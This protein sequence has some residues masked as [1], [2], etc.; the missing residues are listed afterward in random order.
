MP[1]GPVNAALDHLRRAAL[2]A[3][4]G[5]ADAELLGRF[6]EQRDADA[7][8]ALVGRHGPMVWGVCRR[9]LGY[10]DA[11]DAVQATFLVLVRKAAAV[12]PREAVG[13][14]LYGVAHRTALLARRTAARRRAREVQVP[15]LPES[16]AA[17]GHEFDPQLLDA[18]LRRLPDIYRAVLVLC[19]LEGRT[20]AEA[21]RTLGVPE[22]TVAGR[23]ARARALL[24][25]RLAAH[26][27]APAAAA[28]AALA[29]TAAAGS[30]IDAATRV[31]SGQA[32]I[33]VSVAA[34]TTGVT[35]A[36]LFTTV[37]AT[38]VVVLALGLAAA[39]ASSLNGRPAARQ[40][41]A[42]P[43]AAKAADPPPAKQKKDE[44]VVAWG[45]RVGGLQAGLV[46][47]GGAKK[48]FRH[49]DVVTLGVR[50]RNVGKEAV[51]FGYVPQH[52]DENPPTVTDADGATTPQPNLMSLGV[53]HP[54]VTV[55]LEPGKAV[56]LKSHYFNDAGREYALRPAD[57]PR[58]GQGRARPLFVGTGIVT[59]EFERVFGDSSIG[60]AEIPP[61][62]RRLRTGVLE[63]EVEP[64]AA[65]KK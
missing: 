24:A 57:G 50:V 34:L 19:E 22:G 56:E 10:H 7:L 59:V 61:A 48:V 17:V 25:R 11:E 62:L 65:R 9:H 4:A 23:L 54:A 5:P 33:P 29:P 16:A 13:N 28:L 41:G 63:L 3:G 52:L 53:E 31:A 14:W 51:T 18:E 64:A 60:K 37:R 55:T 8:A 21:A 1:T 2:R 6:V 26:G 40:G 45:R 32:A 39:G 43:A 47:R 36:M 12:E 35:N 44:E 30:T 27:A 49:G 42:T 15:A 46:L 20:R 38:A 58:E